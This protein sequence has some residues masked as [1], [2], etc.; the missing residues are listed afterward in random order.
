MFLVGSKY[1]QIILMTISVVC[2]V[3]N[4]AMIAR[5]QIT[6][7]PLKPVIEDLK[8]LHDKNTIS[9]EEL[10]NIKDQLD[11]LMHPELHEPWPLRYTLPIGSGCILFSSLLQLQ[12]RRW[13]SR[14]PLP[15]AVHQETAN[16]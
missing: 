13:K 10:D 11:P 9:S 5:N 12:S 6:C 16:G 3:Y 1:L 8:E 4:S 2:L 14:E 15:K 7:E